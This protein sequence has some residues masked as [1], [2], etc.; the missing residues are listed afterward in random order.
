MR[1]LLA[2]G[3]RVASGGVWVVGVL[4]GKRFSRVSRRVDVRFEEGLLDAGE[5]EK[6]T[7]VLCGRGRGAESRKSPCGELRR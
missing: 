1:G 6:E 7:C 5:R 3:M 2:W 4:G